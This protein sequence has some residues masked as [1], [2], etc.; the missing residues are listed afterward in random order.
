MIQSGKLK[1][2]PQKLAFF[3]D[4]SNAIYAGEIGTGKKT[5]KVQELAK[6]HNVRNP[7]LYFKQLKKRVEQTGRLSRK[8]RTGDVPMLEKKTKQSAKMR[9]AL[10]KFAVKEKYK[11]TYEMAAAHMSQ[12]HL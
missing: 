3:I 4:Y 1:D 11:F 10:E 6:R 8:K 5:G 2:T 9:K 7:K 12:L